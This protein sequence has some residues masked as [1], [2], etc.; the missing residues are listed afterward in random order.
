MA[1]P[2]TG[3]APLTE[4]AVSHASASTRVPLL[5][6]EFAA[7]GGQVQLERRLC[8][9]RRAECRAEVAAAGSESNKIFMVKIGT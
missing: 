2:K 7:G 3:G 6:E 5:G 9:R 8:G 1:S 4:T